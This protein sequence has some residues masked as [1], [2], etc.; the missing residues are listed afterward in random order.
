MK[1]QAC[2]FRGVLV[3]AFILLAGVVASPAIAQ[4][5]AKDA[6]VSMAQNT[7]LVDNDKVRAYE[8]RFKPGDVQ[9]VLPSASYRI[10]RVLSGGTLLRTRV[11][12]TTEPLEWKTGEVKFFEPDTTAYKQTRNVG[13]T[14]VALYIVVLK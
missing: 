13:T 12:G 7:A 8:V 1:L 10:A 2:V 9:T 5:K 6:P 11:D 3:S 4:D 14:D